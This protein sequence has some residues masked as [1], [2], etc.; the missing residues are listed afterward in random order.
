MLRAGETR[1]AR[2]SIGGAAVG[3]VRVVVTRIEN[4]DEDKI[5]FLKDLIPR[6]SCENAKRN[7]ADRDNGGACDGGGRACECGAGGVRR[8]RRQEHDASD[9]GVAR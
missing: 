9:N 2:G 3:I 8:A 5:R 1:D 4:E 6:R 7:E